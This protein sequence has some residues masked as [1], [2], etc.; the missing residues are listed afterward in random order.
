MCW[1]VGGLL[2]MASIRDRIQTD[3]SVKYAVLFRERPTYADVPDV[4]L[5]SRGRADGRSVEATAETCEARGG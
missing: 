5:A 4:G 3:G 2:I 1:P